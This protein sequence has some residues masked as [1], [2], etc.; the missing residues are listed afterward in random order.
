MSFDEDCDHKFVLKL[1]DKS[2]SNR[3]SLSIAT[4]HFHQVIGHFQVST[5]CYLQIQKEG[6]ILIKK[7]VELWL[8][9]IGIQLTI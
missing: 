1:A 7:I 2:A 6:L 4:L 5:G 8:I 3:I 9:E